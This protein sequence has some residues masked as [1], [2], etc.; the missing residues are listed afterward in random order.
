MIRASRVHIEIDVVDACMRLCV[1][2]ADAP[3]SV[4]QLDVADLRQPETTPVAFRPQTRVAFPAELIGQRFLLSLRMTEDDRTELARIAIVHAADLLAR[5][6]RL[7]EKLVCGAVREPIVQ[8]VTGAANGADRVDL[9]IPLER[10]A[11]AA[12]MDID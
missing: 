11:Q 6:H 9:A 10:S 7:L 2:R 4:T 1:A 8:R 5:A 12:D 3:W